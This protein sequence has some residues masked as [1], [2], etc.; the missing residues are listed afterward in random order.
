MGVHGV[1]AKGSARRLVTLVVTSALLATFWSVPLAAPAH[2]ASGT[3]TYVSPS[4]PKYGSGNISW[5]TGSVTRKGTAY[6]W[7]GATGANTG[8]N[9]AQ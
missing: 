4:D 7:R 3:T 5:A 9:I 6:R 8:S 2:A 1:L